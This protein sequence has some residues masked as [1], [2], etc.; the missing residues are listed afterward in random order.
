M[1]SN[2][3][4][5][6]NRKDALADLQRTLRECAQPVLGNIFEVPL[7]GRTWATCLTARAKAAHD[8]NAL[9]ALP[10][11][12]AL[13]DAQWA[14]LDAKA[15]EAVGGLVRMWRTAGAYNGKG[16]RLAW[17]Y[18]TGWERIDILK[19]LAIR[20][21]ERQLSEFAHAMNQN[22]TLSRLSAHVRHVERIIG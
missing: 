15:T 19:R 5:A 14:I 17:T 18:T 9:F 20:I 16:W 13:C 3:S 4:A 21:A 1:A 10:G 8:D 2:C 11:I 6:S 12:V 22:Q 7:L